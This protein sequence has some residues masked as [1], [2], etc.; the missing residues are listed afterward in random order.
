M[1][2][3]CSFLHSKLTKLSKSNKKKCIKNSVS[4]FSKLKD[5]FNHWFRSITQNY[6][7]VSIMLYQF[8]IVTKRAPDWIFW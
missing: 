7:S 1:S 3:T 6:E 4:P 2:T 8:K 5:D